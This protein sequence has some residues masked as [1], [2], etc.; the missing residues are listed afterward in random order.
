MQYQFC[1]KKQNL[2]SHKF[3]LDINDVNIIK[4]FIDQEYKNENNIYI[5]N[6]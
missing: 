4:L 1:L 3:L 6:E 5:F 2:R